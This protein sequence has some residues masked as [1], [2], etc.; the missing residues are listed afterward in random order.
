MNPKTRCY[1]RPELDVLRFFA[2]FLVFWV[3]RSDLAPTDRIAHPWLYHLTVIGVFGVPVFLLLSAYLIAELLLRERQQTGAVHAK[4]F[5]V[6]R[7]LRI[8]PLYFAVF[9][10]LSLLSLAVPGAGSTTPNV[11]LAFL[12][13]AGN[14][15]ITFNGWIEYPLNPLWSIPVEEQFYLAIPFLLRFGTR[16]LVLACAACMVV[17]YLTIAYY[18]PLSTP[19]RGGL[20]TNSLMQFQFFAAGILL[21]IFLKGRAPQWHPLLRLAGIAATIGCWLV[22]SAVFGIQADDPH[23]TLAGALAGWLLVLAGVV[24][25]FFSL[26]GTPAKYLPAPLIYLGRISYGLYMVHITMFWFV[27]AVWKDP[28]IA[29]LTRVHLEGWYVQIGFVSAFTMAVAIAT[30][31]YHWFE[32]PFLRLKQRFTFIPSRDFDE[33]SMTRE[34]WAETSLEVPIDL[35]PSERTA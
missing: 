4:A 3:H 27:Y 25:L 34:E 28:I 23:T 19:G 1:Y 22:A 35:V 14:W 11:W 16:T 6:R 9:A 29:F 26:L 21:A 18:A 20:W 7:I 30:A 33:P 12:L 15:W 5:Y 24:L 31:S 2:F 13:F 10:G 17:A 8:W 32:R